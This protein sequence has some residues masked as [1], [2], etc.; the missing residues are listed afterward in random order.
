MNPG[1][2]LE[3]GANELRGFKAIRT[4]GVSGSLRTTFLT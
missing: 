3:L 2:Y 1:D 4:G